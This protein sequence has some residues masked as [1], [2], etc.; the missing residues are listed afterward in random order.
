MNKKQTRG[1][2]TGSLG[3]VLSAAGSAVG[4]G[5]I[6]RFPY[7]AAKDGGGTFLLF[8]LILVLTFGFTLLTTE[9]AIGRKTGQSPLTAYRKL[10]PKMGWLGLIACLIPMLILPYYSVIG[11]WVLKYLATYLTG[12]AQ[13][14]V[15]GNYFT[16]FITSIWSPILWFL[17]FLGATLF[18]VY[19]GVDAGIER[20]SK[21]LM[22]VLLVLILCISCFSLTL[23]HT[24]DS[25]VTRTGLQGLLVY[26][27]PNFDGMTLRKFLVIL[28]DAMGQLFYS[29]SVAM[30][31]MITYG[32]YV[33]KETNLVKSVNQIVIFDTVVAFLAGMMIIPAVFIFSGTEGMSAG[34]TLMFQS[35][36]KVFGAMGSIGVVV[37]IVFFVTVAF[38]ALTSSVSIMEAIVSSAMDKFHISRQ[39]ACI[40]VTLIT[41]VMGLAVCLGYNLLYFEAVLPNTPAGKNAQI[42]DILDYISNYVMMPVLSIGTCILVGW[43]IK[44]KA[45]IDEVTLG[46]YRFRREKLYVVMVKFVTP[47]LLFF[48]LLQAL[49]IIQF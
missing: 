2:F 35:L 20:M 34:P 31:I 21:I 48:L 6:W 24:D 4:L 5:N 12:G 17:I 16:G 41:L 18:V 42:L 49:G 11:G 27:V 3:F 25:G 10:Q 47:L 1:R 37:G 8:Y 19:K 30:G 14:A 39:K 36:P 46:G 40:A 23:S 29:I 38:A 26:V 33:K 43:M 13:A 9:I 22:P 45:I 44:P 32:S 15:D 7:L 28:T